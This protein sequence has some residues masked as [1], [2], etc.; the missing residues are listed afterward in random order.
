MDGGGG[1]DFF[2]FLWSSFALRAQV[3]RLVMN[4]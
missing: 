4:S 1:L 3:I 2:L